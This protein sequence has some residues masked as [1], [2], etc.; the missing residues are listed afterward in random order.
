[1]IKETNETVCAV[2]VTY[3]RKKLLIKC[4]ESI[5]NQTRPVN[6]IYIVDNASTDGTPEL[7]LKK[8]YITEI[9]PNNISKSLQKTFRKDDILIHY[10]RNHENT[11]GAGGFYNGIK[12]A[13]EK[14]YEWLWLM[15]DDSEPKIDALEKL[16]FHFKDQDLSAIVNSVIDINDNFLYA[17]RGYFN[18]NR[19]LPVPQIL[20]KDDY[21]GQYNIEV[22]FAGF[23][24]VLVN[25]KTIKKVGFVKKEFFIFVDDL[26][27][28]YR[29]RK[30]G[31]I[32]LVSN[33]FIIHK[34]ERSDNAIIQK[35]IL[36]K[37]NIFGKRIIR[38]SYKSYWTIYFLYRNLTWLGKNY[39]KNKSSLYLDVVLKYIYHLI[40]IILLDD[41]KKKRIHLLTSSF[42][43]G[44]KGN[45]NNQKPKRILYGEQK[46][47]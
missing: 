19:G 32:L 30:I 46:N 14:D 25:R 41:H 40:T 8:G 6:A 1:M 43:D 31:K 44:L 47:N 9:P 7:L 39:T 42:S 18:F 11:G 3:N 35:K 2:I 45:F 13:Y 21:N 20:S 27:Y 15:D 38:R 37:D 17:T 23:V 33:S 12:N 22:D 28:C 10:F 5:E 4:L 34:A 16:S 26:E 24:G 29:L 36:G